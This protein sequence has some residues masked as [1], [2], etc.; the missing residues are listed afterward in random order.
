MP[1]F[2][3]AKPSRE[4][5]IERAR[6]H[7]QKEW[8]YGDFIDDNEDRVDQAIADNESPED[9]IDRLADKYGLSPAGGW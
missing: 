1:K 2:I 4:E 5:F 9:F 7:A 3:G 6:A 8:A